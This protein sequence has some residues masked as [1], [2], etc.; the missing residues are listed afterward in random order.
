[1]TIEIQSMTKLAVWYEKLSPKSNFIS[2]NINK[3]T[4]KQRIN[5]KILDCVKISLNHNEAPLTGGLFNAGVGFAVMI[6]SS[7][8]VGFCGVIVTIGVVDV[9]ITF[10][11]QS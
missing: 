1:M 3:Y 7:G 4:M 6:G 10:Y 8:I 11:T 5:N 9:L 2:P